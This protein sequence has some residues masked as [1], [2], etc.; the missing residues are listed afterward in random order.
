MRDDEEVLL[1]RLLT[2]QKPFNLIENN[3]YHDRLR[4]KKLG[5][6][7][8]KGIIQLTLYRLGYVNCWGKSNSFYLED[9]TNGN[10]VFDFRLYI[11]NKYGRFSFLH[12]IDSKNWDDYSETPDSIADV[13]MLNVNLKVCHE[14]HTDMEKKPLI[15]MNK[16]NMPRLEKLKINADV[17]RMN[18]VIDKDTPK[19]TLEEMIEDGIKQM[20]KLLSYEVNPRNVSDSDRLRGDILKGYDS[21][22]LV[23]K[24]GRSEDYINNLRSQINRELEEYKN[25]NV[26]LNQEE[27]IEKRED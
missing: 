2:I 7:Y 18:C 25:F 4:K 14:E 8:L 5:E 3:N 12:N 27:N 10:G 11:I 26:T 21:Q 20:T 9:Y 19:E 15:T 22:W 17:I 1:N 13:W 23:D 24:Y 16:N 6:E